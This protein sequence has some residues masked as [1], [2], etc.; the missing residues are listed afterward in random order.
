[1]SARVYTA[2]G[3]TGKVSVIA[4]ARPEVVAEIQAC[5]WASALCLNSKEDKVYCADIENREVAVIDAAADV[6]IARV[7]VGDQ[8]SALSYDS[9]NDY[10]YC[11]CRGSNDVYV[12]NAHRDTVVT[13]INVG[14]EPSALA[15]NPL[16]LRT[17]VLNYA[18]ASVAVLRDSLHPGVEEMS[19]AERRMTNGRATV[20]SGVLNLGVDSRQQTGYR[21]ELLD[22][23]G[24]KLLNLKVGANDV[25][26]LAPG[27]YFV[28][29]AQAQAQAVQKIVLTR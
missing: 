28:R 9:L 18:S 7:P 11:T 4:G 23:S 15:W 6:V 16:D 10:V 22:I 20:V 2:N 5:G 29:E 13:H 25:R 21:A 27:V 17:Y 19:N 24:R 26:A 8:P 1:V 14:A 3:S 12:I